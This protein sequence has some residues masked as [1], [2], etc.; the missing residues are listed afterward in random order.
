MISLYYYY[1]AKILKTYLERTT[2]QVRGHIAV[3]GLQG[4]HVGLGAYLA[5]NVCVGSD[6]TGIENGRYIVLVRTCLLYTSRCV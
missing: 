1:R 4:R 3:A 5:V 6:N 2:K